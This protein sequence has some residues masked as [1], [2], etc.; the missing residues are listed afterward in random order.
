M[1][2]GWSS[3]VNKLNP[4]REW[5]VVAAGP[6]IEELKEAYFKDGIINFT[7][8]FDTKI[9]LLVSSAIPDFTT[10]AGN[11]PCWHLKGKATFLTSSRKDEEIEMHYCAN[12]SSDE[13]FIVAED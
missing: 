4:Y 3:A 1:T 5:W 6:T 2:A 13:A 9:S 12:P 11:R 8:G 10:R 7:L